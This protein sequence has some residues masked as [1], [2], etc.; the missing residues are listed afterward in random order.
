[1]K[2]NYQLEM[3]SKGSRVDKEPCYS[4]ETH[5]EPGHKRLCTQ[6]GVAMNTQKAVGKLNPHIRFSHASGLN[7]LFYSRTHLL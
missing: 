6:S 1:M 4:H 5:R 2:Q 7:S 3:Q